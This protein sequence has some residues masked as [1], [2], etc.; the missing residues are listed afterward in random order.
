MKDADLGQANS[1][2]VKA[3]EGKVREGRD[4]DYCG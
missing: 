1:K 3:L 2:V 4:E